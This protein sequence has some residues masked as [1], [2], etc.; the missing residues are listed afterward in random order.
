[1]TGFIDH[2]PGLMKVHCGW[3]LFMNVNEQKEVQAEAARKGK[4]VKFDSEQLM[5]A[6]QGA[7]SEQAYNGALGILRLANGCAADYVAKLKQSDWVSYAVADEGGYLH[8]YRCVELVA[9]EQHHRR[10]PGK[11][12][13]IPLFTLHEQNERRSGITQRQVSWGE[14]SCAVAVC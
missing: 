9:R 4:G 2:F 10:Q 13:R 8:A 3:H 11:C 14:A 6:I 1:M 12:V 7:E 5:W